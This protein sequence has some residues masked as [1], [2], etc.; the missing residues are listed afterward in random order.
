MEAEEELENRTH[1]PRCHRRLGIAN[2][3]ESIAYQRR[4]HQCILT[5]VME[6]PGDRKFEFFIQFGKYSTY[7]SWQETVHN[8]TLPECEPY[9]WSSKT[10]PIESIRKACGIIRK[11][12][13]AEHR[14]SK[15]SGIPPMLKPEDFLKPWAVMTLMPD[16]GIRC[17]NLVPSLDLASDPDSLFSTCEFVADF[18]KNTKKET[19]K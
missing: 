15:M 19:M 13:I 18:V 10:S 12:Y 7:F 17:Q 9:D 11:K 4:H 1:C 3:L 16:T 2:A 8:R 14:H 6:F 5:K